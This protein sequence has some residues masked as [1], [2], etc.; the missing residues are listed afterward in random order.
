LLTG[1]LDHTLKLWALDWELEDKSPI[2]WDDSAEPY[3]EIF[4]RQHTPYGK[5]YDRTSDLQEKDETRMALTRSGKPVWSEDDFEHF[6]FTLGC[7]G[8]GWLSP[9]SIR[10]RLNAKAN[11]K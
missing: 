7:A 10:N 8:L 6:L 11:P 4:I 1:S 9:D 3:L 5:K 2:D